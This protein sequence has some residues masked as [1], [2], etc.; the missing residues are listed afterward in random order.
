[1]DNFGV[2][3]IKMRVYFSSY[4]LW[5]ADHLAKLAR[6]IE[7]THLRR[8][9]FDI[10]HRAYVTNSIF[11]SV[12]FMESA[13][14]E[15]FQDASER[16][17][18]YLSSL[19]EQ[20]VTLLADYCNRTTQKKRRGKSILGKYKL[21]L[22]LCGKKPFEEEESPYKEVNHVV[23]LRNTL[24]HYKPQT[25]GGDAIHQLTSQLMGQFPENKLMAGSGNPYFPDK[26]LGYGC[27]EWATSSVR[28]FCDV[29]FSEIGVIPNYQ[30]VNF[31]FAG[32]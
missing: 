15:L 11:S 30:Q 21:S 7:D 2:P 29:F 6:Q 26:V 13:I 9:R 20:A 4:H 16:Y 27:A 14:N 22:H 18:A 12:A 17:T 19:P 28:K 24:V 23:Q 5:A 10:K 32:G 1:M 8:S 31:S 25:L 3:T